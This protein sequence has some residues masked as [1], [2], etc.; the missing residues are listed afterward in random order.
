[1]RK[2][3]TI[4]S[5]LEYDVELTLLTTEIPLG[6]SNFTN[7]VDYSNIK[8]IT[9]PNSPLY[10]KFIS[11][12]NKKVSPFRKKIKLFLRK[13]YYKFSMYDPLKQSIKNAKLVLDQIENDYDLIISVSDP[14]SSHL[15]TNT[16]LKMKN[17]KYKKYIQ[18]WGD[19]MTIDIT[20]SKVI[21]K[22]LIKK[23]EEKLL[24]V[25][26]K[27]YYVSPLTLQKQKEIFPKQAKK[28]DI[29]FPAYSQK[30][31]YEKVNNI[32][33]I[34]YFGDYTS[35]VRNI[36]PL[37]NAVSDSK[38][39]LYICGNTDLNL[40]S[41]ENRLIRPRISVDEV[42]KLE[43]EMDLLIHLS[44]KKG[45]QIPGKLYQYMGTNK[46]ILFILD[47]D[48]ESLKKIF[49]PFNRFYFCDNDSKSIREAIDYINKDL[50]HTSLD[51][52][53]VSDFDFKNIGK[54]LLEGM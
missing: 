42:K 24:S 12:R 49:Q 10:S 7:S 14:K 35:S 3:I 36:L 26:D 47:G 2:I 29:L 48:K 32:K 21:P 5:L 44:N 11:K 27:V 23:E 50:K 19:P 53:P 46:P 25:A 8:K 38:Y 18:I 37:Y 22:L 33:N 28:M 51:I 40:P 15:L 30:K 52:N 54:I 4:K 20:K 1:L 13:I 17:I 39:K 34:G 9:I 45:T 43:A 16:I 6:A 41:D 31:I